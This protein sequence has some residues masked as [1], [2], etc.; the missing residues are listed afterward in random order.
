MHWDIG[1]S[2][3]PAITAGMKMVKW[4]AEGKQQFLRASG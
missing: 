4:Y 2:A 3:R 1:I